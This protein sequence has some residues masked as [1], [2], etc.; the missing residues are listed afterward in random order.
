MDIENIENEGI[1]YICLIKYN[2]GIFIYVLFK[3]KMIMKVFI[4][5]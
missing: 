5:Q 1:F 3:K 4:N 2:E